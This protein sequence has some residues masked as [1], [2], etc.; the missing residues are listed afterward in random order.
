MT[1]MKRRGFLGAMLAAP[2][3][4]KEVMAQASKQ[5]AP[6]LRKFADYAMKSDHQW[7]RRAANVT[8]IDPDILSL[9]LPVATMFRMQKARNY[10]RIKAEEE[11]SFSRIVRRDGQFSFWG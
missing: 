11:F 3:A 2:I 6:V 10:E 9:R 7:R 1:E 5:L 4:G 8:I